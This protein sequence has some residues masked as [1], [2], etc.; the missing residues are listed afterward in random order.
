MNKIIFVND[1]KET[2]MLEAIEKAGING[3]ITGAATAA[4]FGL[5]A[6]VRTPF[7]SQNTM[8]LYVLTFLGGS[9][10]S[11]VTD[12]IHE[13]IQEEIP[14]SQKVNDQVSIVTSMA[15]NAGLFYGALYLCDASVASDFG[16]FKALAIGAGSEWVGSAT[17]TQLK[18]NM[19]I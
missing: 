2:K 3:L 9:L 19:F 6:Q 8:P 17:Y 4:L 10:S 7:T 13:F 18:E 12:G 16:A 1:I 5:Q 15:L 11:L 14:V